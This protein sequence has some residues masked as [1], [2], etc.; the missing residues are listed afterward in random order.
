MLG[1]VHRT[2]AITQAYWLFCAVSGTVP[3]GNT[4]FAAMN[5]VCALYNG[6]LPIPDF[7]LPVMRG[8]GH[9]YR[10]VAAHTPLRTFTLFTLLRAIWRSRLYRQRS[11]PV[12]R[13]G[14]RTGSLRC[15]SN[16]SVH[17]VVK[18]RS[19]ARHNSPLHAVTYRP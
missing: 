9:R 19:I 4:A 18:R 5:R 1:R 17:R 12:C 16:S 10:C 7:V 15:V 14:G 6:K 13:N 3:I 8:E 11:A 2:Y